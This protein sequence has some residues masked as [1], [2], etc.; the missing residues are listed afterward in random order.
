MFYGH[1]LLSSSET[2][3]ESLLFDI[4]FASY[5]VRKYPESFAAGPAWQILG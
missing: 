4:A 3:S 2:R 1:E 5:V